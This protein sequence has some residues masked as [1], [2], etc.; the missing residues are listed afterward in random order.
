MKNFLLNS[1]LIFF[2]LALPM[3]PALL[4]GCATSAAGKVAQ[5]EK[6]LIQTVND[7]MTE[8]AAYVKAGKA[9]AA[10]VDRIETLY[11]AYYDAQQIAKAAIEHSLAGT[12]SPADLATANAAVKNAEQTLLSALNQILRP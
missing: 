9:R 11:N 2:C 8:W 7:G 6:I 10:D 4:V 12:G 5:G 3:A 1:T